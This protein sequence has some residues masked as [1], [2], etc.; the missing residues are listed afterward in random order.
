MCVLG[1]WE[2]MGSDTQDVG[3]SPTVRTH[4]S[5]NLVLVLDYGLA[6]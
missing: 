1:Y 6:K 2:N 5:V 4:K 3:S